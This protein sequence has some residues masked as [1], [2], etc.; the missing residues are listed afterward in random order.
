MGLLD[1]TH[2]G[3]PH[4]VHTAARQMEA[5]LLQ[6]VL[7]SSGAFHSSET[8]GSGVNADLFVDALAEAVSKGG[9]LG[10][11]AMLERSLGGAAS[12][13]QQAPPLPAFSP[14]VAPVAGGVVT[15]H[16][17]P[18]A[19]PFDGH[20][21][22]HTGVDIG[23]PEGTPIHAVSG[24]VVRAAGAHGG[25]G[26]RLEVDNGGGRTTIYAH[27]SALLVHAGDVVAPG[28]VIGKVGSTGRSTGPHLHLELRQGGQAIDAG[29]VLKLYGK[30]DEELGVG[31][32]GGR[33]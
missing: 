12:T 28:Q 32:E 2:A 19:D 1:G 8:A 14:S 31:K 27:A 3:Q 26:N 11:A 22:E 15:S 17:G 30:R 20:E 10:L 29:R 25:L 16:F 18:R 24:G 13:S 23:A 5:M 33:P 6:Q 4:D 21:A 7:K 9:G